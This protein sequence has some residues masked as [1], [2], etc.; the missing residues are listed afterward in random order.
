MKN[1]ILI[2]EDQLKPDQCNQLIQWFEED[3]EHHTPG[4]LGAGVVVENIKHSTDL[5]LDFRDR[6]CRYREVL[7]PI[8]TS[9]MTRYTD[10]YPFVLELAPWGVTNAYNIQRY[11]D[12]EGFFKLHCEAMTKVNWNRMVA[13]TLYLNDSPCGTDYPEQ[14][15]VVEAKQGRLALFPATWTH[16]HKGV[17]PNVGTKY[18]A[19]GWIEMVDGEQAYHVFNK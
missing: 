2:L 16:P 17:T 10:H 4:A 18:I 15:T 9:G 12:G 19:T 11:T 7:F 5:G 1:Q 3:E 8:V 6:S 13:W 14:E